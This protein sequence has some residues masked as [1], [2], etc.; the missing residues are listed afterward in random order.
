MAA[1]CVHVNTPAVCA[2][3]A[4]HYAFLS[5]GLSDLLSPLGLHK[6]WTCSL[7]GNIA[8]ALKQVD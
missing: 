1:T 2:D 3:K 7:E 4:W 8:G 5:E 6:H